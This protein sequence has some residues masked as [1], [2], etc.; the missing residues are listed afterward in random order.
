MSQEIVDAVRVLGRE[1][2]I[3]EE[4]LMLALEDALLSA[5][6]KQPGAA[7]YARVR[8]DRDSGDFRVDELLL[9]PDLEE[10]LLDEAEEAATL[11]E[12]RVDPETGE[13][14]IPEAPDIDPA[15]LAEF[16]QVD[17]ER[18]DHSQRIKAVIKEVSSSTRGPSIIVSRRDPELIKKLFE[19]EV[20]EIADG[21]VEITNVA[22]EPGYRSKIAVVSHQ[23]GVDPVGACVG[24]RGSRV[25]MVV[26]ELRGEKIDIIPYNDEPA[27]FVAKA[28]S[29]AR[30]TG[31]RIDIK[32]ETEFATEDG[33][34]YGGEGEEQ[35]DDGRCHAILTNGRRCP[36]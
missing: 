35:Q 28:L 19:L 17:G 26:S 27:R 14:I 32:S 34:D 36:N 12:R 31:W 23:Q 22:R 10:Q 1:K 9:P 30:V 15:R 25:R 5:Y 18:Y 6:K 16:E 20:P 21:L 33:E 13:V 11:E 4:K 3:S 8:M 29:P 2:G 24:P 7:R